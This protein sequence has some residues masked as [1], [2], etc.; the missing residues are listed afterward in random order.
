MKYHQLG[1][2]SI[3]VSEVSFG[4]MSL[5][6]RKAD[7]MALIREAFDQ[8]INY[9]DTADLYDAGENEKLVGEALK[10]IRNEIVLATKVGNELR[11]DGSGW[12]WNPRKSYIL[13]AV[14]KSL[15][16]L[17]TDYIDLYQLHGGTIEDPIDE[18]IEAFEQLKKE[19]KI[20][21]YGISSIRP[22]V[23]RAYLEKSS[24]VSVMMQYSLLDRRPE[25]ECLELLAKN[26]ISVLVRGA[27]AKGLLLDKPVKPYLNWSEKEVGNIRGKLDELSSGLV[28]KTELILKYLLTQPAVISI[29]SGIRTKE[30]LHETLKALNSSGQW[31][32]VIAQLKK[33]LPINKYDTHR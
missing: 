1:K 14:E 20:R 21:E 8:G 28:E 2:S 15:Q 33:E 6:G 24:M 31:D 7:D 32:Q 26:D 9:F 16:S 30:Q 12:D 10:G 29:V 17:Q 3:K 27:Y 25:E 5:R 4:C 19:G 18:T 23:I 22:N 11:P 13:K